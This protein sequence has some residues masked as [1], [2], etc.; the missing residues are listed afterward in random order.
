MLPVKDALVTLRTTWIFTTLLASVVA[1]CAGSAPPGKG[2][3]Y[4]PVVSAGE[5][6]AGGQPADTVDP[7][8][9]Y[10]LRSQPPPLPKF[11]TADELLVEKPVEA[12]S[13]QASASVPLE[14]S[15]PSAT[16]P[17]FEPPEPITAENPPAQMPPANAVEPAEEELFQPGQIVARVGDQIIL[18]GDVAPLAEQTLGP[19]LAKAKTQAERDEI[20][21]HRDEVTEQ[22]VRSVIET[23]LLYYETLREIPRDKLEEAR[24][25]MK[26][27]IAAS[28][29]A[30]LKEARAEVAATKKSD[31][32][33][34]LRKDPV[35]MRLALMMQ[36]QKLETLPELDAALRAQG[37]S[38][39]KQQSFYGE[40]HIGRSILPQKI[41]FK[42][43]VT[44]QEMLDYYRDHA[45][46]FAVAA[47]ARFELMSVSYQ[48]H[49]TRQ[50]AEQALAEMG[51]AVYL[52][53]AS[54]ASVA[55]KS[56]DDPSASR[57]G[58]YDWTSRA[59]LASEVVDAAVFS[60]P[61]GKLSEILR[62]ERGCYIVRVIERTDAAQVPFTDAQSKIKT[63]IVAEKRDEQYKKYVESLRD[64]TPVWTIYDERNVAR[65]PRGERSR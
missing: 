65:E 62:D 58:Q 47:K 64:S 51:N 17:L 14:S 49:P 60:L 12:D 19:Y 24:K 32:E 9:R 16:L 22:L 42:P 7:A 27:K 15:P 48:K 4:A 34:V 6:I 10:P 21:S 20:L 39:A 53:G 52:G 57:G 38:L 63:A 31:L 59:S 25:Q 13:E 8:Q 5:K 3:P 36:E 44:H 43:E 1:G 41:N 40:Y 28:F 50:A 2:D 11:T 33:Q 61:P 29:E 54:F 18:Y 46:D 26:H 56:S 23:K 55:Q 35:L 37:S 45:D 30:G